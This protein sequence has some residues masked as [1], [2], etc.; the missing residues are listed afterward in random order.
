MF[1]GVNNT[2]EFSCVVE[3]GG[4]YEI[5]VGN[6]YTGYTSDGQKK[7][8]HLDLGKEEDRNRI[9]GHDI[10]VKVVIYS[11]APDIKLSF[12]PNFTNTLSNTYIDSSFTAILS[13]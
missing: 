11:G 4:N 6:V 10:F 7:E 3:N 9:E 12:D 5:E 13:P 2:V 8:Y 1:L